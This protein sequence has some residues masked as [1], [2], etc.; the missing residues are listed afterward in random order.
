MNPKEKS[1]IY[2]S[3]SQSPTHLEEVIKQ[4]KTEVLVSEVVSHGDQVRDECVEERVV[5]V[6]LCVTHRQ[7]G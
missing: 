3:L 6:T 2:N 7:A 4:D 1:V 5:K